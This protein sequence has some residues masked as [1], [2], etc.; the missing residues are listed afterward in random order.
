M[1]VTTSETGTLGLHSLDN[2]APL[3]GAAA[4]ERILKK[5][6]RLR[7][8]HAVH[9]SSTFY[10]GGVTEILTPL[11]LM[12][13]ALGIETGWRL[14]QGTP[15]FFTCTKK[16]HNTLQGDTVDF[17]IE[18]KATYE[19]VMFENALRLHIDNCD[20]VIVHDPQPLPLVTHLKEADTPWIW[21]CHVDL[22]SPNPAAWN[23]LRRFVEQYD[24][25][26]FSLPEY[27]KGPRHPSAVHHASDQSIR[28]Q[29]PRTVGRRDRGL[30]GTLPHPDRSSA[31][32]ADL[33]F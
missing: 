17:T 24:M 18:E 12:M 19:Q 1:S 30:F 14:V 6:E 20:A 8:L 5:A 9:I 21:Q 10:G 4:I 7:T 3:I 29:E 32:R 28:G 15:E 25:A 13:N 16:L 23:Y 22:S 2:Y 26:I 11:T 31:G 27:A 33:S